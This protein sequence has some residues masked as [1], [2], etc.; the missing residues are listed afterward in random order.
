MKKVY[1]EILPYIF[2]IIGVVLVRSFIVTPV[3]VDGAS[4]MPT[5]KNNDILLLNK[6]D[7]SYQRFDIVVIEYNNTRLVKR[8][9][10]LPGDMI[11]YKNNKLYVNGKYVK[12]EFL[13]AQTDDFTIRYLG[14]NKVPKDCYFVMG[15]NRENSMDSRMIGFIPKKQILGVTN[16]TL[17][18]FQ[19]F[20]T[21]E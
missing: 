4:M 17:F 15:D 6:M 1:K 2:I 7:R 18:P 14:E 13:S 21:I 20:G 16:F 9:I 8:I 3:R 11:E 5:L 19:K 12:E 10:G